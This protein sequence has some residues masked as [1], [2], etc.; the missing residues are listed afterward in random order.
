MLKVL[1]IDDDESICYSIKR[2]LSNDYDIFTALSFDQACTFLDNEDIDFIFLDYQLGEESGLDVLKKIRGI[3]KDIPVA[4][5]TAHGTSEILM[6]AIRFGAV[7]FL[8]KPVDSAKLIFTIEKYSGCYNKDYDSDM[9]VRIPDISDSEIV[10]AESEAMKD[11]LKN[12]AVISETRSPVL[13]TGE[14][15]TGKDVLARLIHR[16][17]PRKD[18][19]FVSINCAAIPE[20][21]LE[22]ELFGHVKGSF[23]GALTSKLGKFQIADKGTIFLDEMG[24][25]PI[26]LQAKLLH[27]LQDGLIQKV[28][29]NSFHKVDIRII[30]ATNKPLEKLVES[31]LFREDLF[32]RINAFT[33]DIPPLRQRKAD[34]WP[35]CL[36]YLGK[37]TLE[38][39]KKISHIEKDCQNMLEESFWQGNVRELKNCMAKAAVM[40]STCHI[41]KEQ[42]SALVN[43][44]KSD[45]SDIYDYFSSKYDKELL[46]SSVEELEKAIIKRCLQDENNN[47]TTTAK[48]LGISRV[49]LYDKIK[50]YGL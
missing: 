40:T 8:A 25:M 38:L 49:T 23:T 21:L 39:K 18:K 10:I 3:K 26:Q 13:L 36:Y 46:T 27:V 28:G 43:T 6:D 35:L 44:D 29:D 16:Y 22:S 5:L 20:T 41:G 9:Y 14:S 33:I 50:R 47:H 31:G 37:Q 17:S 4:F 42:I 30:S 34:I 32:Y 15:G 48:K 2:S 19:P 24:D 11:I 7:D 1:L 12:I 45:A